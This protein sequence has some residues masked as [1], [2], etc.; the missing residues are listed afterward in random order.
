MR[1]TNSLFS[2]WSAPKP[3]NSA[4]FYSHVHGSVLM[5]NTGIC[6]LL[7]PSDRQI[8]GFGYTVNILD[9]KIWSANQKLENFVVEM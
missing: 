2:N 3:T 8:Y 5:V 7:T 9:E 4:S 1:C 6:L